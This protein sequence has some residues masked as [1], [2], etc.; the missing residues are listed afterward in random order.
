ML[1]RFLYKIQ[2]LVDRMIERRL[3]GGW[4][5][6]PDRMPSCDESCSMCGYLCS[7]CGRP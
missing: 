1:L 3:H 5:R 7:R 2:R 6:S 4:L